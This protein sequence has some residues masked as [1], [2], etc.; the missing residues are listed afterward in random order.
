MYY[1]VRK[2][3]QKGIFTDWNECED[4]ILGFHGAEYKGFKTLEEAQNY[5]NTLSLKENT[6][7]D[8]SFVPE[9]PDGTVIAF[10]DGSFDSETGKYGYGC[11]LTD[12][13]SILKE[14]SGSGED[15]QAASSHNIAGEL[16]ATM[17]A[18]TWA[19]M[20]G[21]KHIKICHDYQ[22]I[23]SW[24]NRTWK[25]QSYVSVKYI[26][27]MER[28]NGVLEISFVKIEAHTGVELNERADRLAKKGAGI[29]Q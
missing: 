14:I 8:K 7:V 25:A 24:Y 5:L 9:C 22:G 23:A 18:S 1:A 26:E 10:V 6:A 15:P 19:A 27:Y 11:V 20:Q 17:Y 13:K 16:M 2:G 21:F 3:R 12:G 28:F 29:E 4:S